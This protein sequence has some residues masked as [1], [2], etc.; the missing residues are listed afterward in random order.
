MAGGRVV[1]DNGVVL[2][3]LMNVTQ[4]FHIAR[5]GIKSKHGEVCEML[6]LLR[7]RSERRPYP[8]RTV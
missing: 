2:G 6:K 1:G 7:V 3:S 5:S 4:I 8:S